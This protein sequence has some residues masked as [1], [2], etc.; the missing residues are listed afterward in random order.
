MAAPI[1]LKPLADDSG[2]VS[3][4]KHT[5]QHTKYPNIF[6]LGDCSNIPTSKTAAAVAGQSGVLTHN[7]L[8]LMEEADPPNFKKVLIF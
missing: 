2:F 7:L 6:A 8:Q 5:L 1:C 3:V 4:D